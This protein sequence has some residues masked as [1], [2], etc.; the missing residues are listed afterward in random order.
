ME[1][2]A[3]LAG[4]VLS[5]NVSAGERIEDGQAVVTLSSMKMEIP[6]TSQGRG[7][8]AEVL[9]QEGAEVDIGAV[10]ARVESDT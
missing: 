8:V 1:I 10:L 3:P 2:V 4:V 6:V 7:R 9:V 5:V